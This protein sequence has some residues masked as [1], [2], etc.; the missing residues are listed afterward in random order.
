MFKLFS[1]KPPP[2]PAGDWKMF[3]EFACI[4]AEQALQAMREA[5]HE[6]D[7]RCVDAVE[8][9]RRWLTGEATELELTAAENSVSSIK[10]EIEDTQDAH[11]EKFKANGVTL[12]ALEEADK[13]LGEE[14]REQE[15]DWR[16]AHTHIRSGLY[17]KGDDFLRRT[18]GIIR[19]KI[20]REA[21]EAIARAVVKVRKALKRDEAACRPFVASREITN[22][23]ADC[24]V[25]SI[26]VC[27]VTVGWDV[28]GAWDNAEEAAL[29]AGYV[30]MYAGLPDGYM[31]K[32]QDQ[33]LARIGKGLSWPGTPRITTGFTLRLN[34]SV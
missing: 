7:Q 19:P 33:A 5:G 34:R 2:P 8:V 24:I 10:T 15:Y 17:D 1:K 28:D 30:G 25:A 18:G 6:P 13:L 16:A 29:Q 14:R 27:G 21:R 23:L 9:L 26:Q 4:C 20:V 3:D 11:M 12:S 32:M 22:C 31:V